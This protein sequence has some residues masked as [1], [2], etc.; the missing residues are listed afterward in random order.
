MRMRRA[1]H[2]G[3]GLIRTVY[4]IGVVAGAGHEAMILAPPK[5]FADALRCHLLPGLQK[6]HHLPI[7]RVGR[8]RGAPAAFPDG[9]RLAIFIGMNT[10]PPRPQ[11]R[12]LEPSG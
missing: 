3:I 9:E 7:D 12:A 5:W 1:N 2:A 10:M 6:R 11:P 4:V 8:R